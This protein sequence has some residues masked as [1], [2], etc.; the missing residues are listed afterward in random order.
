MSCEAAHVHLVDNRPRGRPIKWC[1]PLP[2]VGVHIY[3]HALHGSRGIFAGL[4]SSV[5]TVVLWN[6]HAAPVRIEEDFVRVETHSAP[7]IENSFSP[8]AVNLPSFYARYKNV[9]IVI[10]P[11]SCRINRNHTRRPSIIDTIKKK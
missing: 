8:K 6:N 4:P 7:R 3:D 11:V 10:G 2:I 5:A 1:V 9:P